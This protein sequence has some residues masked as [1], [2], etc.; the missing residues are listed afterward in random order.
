MLLS[1]QGPCISEGWAGV[2][3]CSSSQE[4]LGKEIHPTN[5]LSIHPS[6]LPSLCPSCE[7]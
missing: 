5:H 2:W 4:T 1:G 6:I 3:I 7:Y